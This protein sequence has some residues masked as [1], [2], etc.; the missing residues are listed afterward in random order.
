MFFFSSIFDL[1]GVVSILPFLSVLTEPEII[2]ENIF[3][4]KLNSYL[5]LEVEEFVIFLGLVSFILVILNQCLRLFSRVC[6]TAY[7]RNLIFKNSRELFNFYLNKPYN[8]FLSQNNAHLIQK[9]TNYV[10]AVISGFVSPFLFISSNF[11]TTIFILSFL[12]Y[13]QP[14]ITLGLIILL[15]IFYFSIYKKLSKKI[16]KIGQSYPKYFSMSSAAIGDAF[17]SIKQLKLTKNSFFFVNKFSDAAK[18][19]RNSNI[20]L[21]LFIGLPSISIEI[22]AYGILLFVSLFLFLNFDNFSQFIPIVGVLAISLK[23]VMPSAQDIY[24]QILQI[25]FHNASFSKIINDF[26]NSFLL[27]NKRALRNSKDKK[28]QFDKEVNF[29]KIEFSY[30]SSKNILSVNGK[31]KQGQFI[32]ICGKS[33]H[34]K[35]TFLDIFCGLLSPTSGKIMIDGIPFNKQYIESWQKKIGYAPQ[36]GYILNDT[37]QNNIALGSAEL[38]HFKKIQKIC[39]VVEISRFIETRLSKKYNSKLGEGGIGMSGGQQQRLIIARA[40]YH[41]PQLIILDEA[42]NALDNITERKILKNIRKYFPKATILFVT[43]R[44]KSLKRCDNILLFD[45]GKVIAEGTYSFLNR[46][47]KVFRNMNIKN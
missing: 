40:L 41:D 37:I 13:Y 7:C 26:E 42:T 23:R 47:S 6:S 12:F 36:S 27:S 44:V 11:F 32:G 2:N 29:K 33:G 10:E 8:F 1:V 9:C 16:D 45:K 5:N 24:A 25:K 19:Y 21:N 38:K 28:I 46:K 17:G 15:P 14:I 18:K 35:T 4:I 3:L 22:L 43:H 39:K 34:G 30:D 31:I 20:L